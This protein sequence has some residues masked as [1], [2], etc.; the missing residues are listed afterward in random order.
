MLMIVYMERYAGDHERGDLY[1]RPA[2]SDE[3]VLLDRGRFLPP[4]EVVR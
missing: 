2:V 3:D 4:S 1:G